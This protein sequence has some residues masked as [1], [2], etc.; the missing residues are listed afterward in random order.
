MEKYIRPHP[1]RPGIWVFR[2]KN[3]RKQC[4][5]LEAAILER[6]ITLAQ[7]RTEGV[8]L[9]SSELH[10]YRR[11][12]KLAGD[13]PLDKIVTEWL[14]IYGSRNAPALRD[15]LDQWL[16]RG[17]QK[18]LAAPTL[19][20][21]R[22][23]A[24]KIEKAFSGKTLAEIDGKKLLDWYFELPGA[25]RTRRSVISNTIAFLNFCADKGWIERA[26]TIKRH[27]LERESSNAVEVFSVAEVE[28]I[29]DRVKKLFPRYLPNFA[30]RAYVGLRTTEASKMKWDWIDFERKRIVIPAEI[31]KTRDA[32]VLQ[33]P[34]LPDKVFRVLADVRK[35]CGPIPAPYK[36]I[37]E[38]L[39]KELGFEWKHNGLRHTFCTM[40][41]SFF[42]DAAK[43]ATLLKHR[44][45][46][47]LYRHYCGQ[48]VPQEEAAKYFA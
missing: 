48:L 11:A 42:G 37:R 24:R 33:A 32:W 13:V 38:Q 26:P 28:A 34:V 39:R 14:R 23:S 46:S 17:E 40:H 30:L 25:A 1:T 4:R 19:V 27:Q 47:V 43:T 35:E 36:D 12:K 9:M 8:I 15:A 7:E 6:E 5:S 31:C 45:I 18:R 21:Y 3:V 44:G 16:E 29:F 2:Y 10:E 41:I 20:T 22:V